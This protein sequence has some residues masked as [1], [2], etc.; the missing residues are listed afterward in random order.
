MTKIN[1]AR[2]S[3]K[4]FHE[5]VIAELLVYKDTTRKGGIDKEEWDC[6]FLEKYYSSVFWA[7][8]VSTGE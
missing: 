4:N 2:K 7:T 3:V 5:E 8:V 6:I 1:Q